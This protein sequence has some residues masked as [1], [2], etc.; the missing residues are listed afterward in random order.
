MPKVSPPKGPAKPEGRSRIGTGKELL[1]NVDHRSQTMRRYREVYGQ[2]VED[3]GGDPSEA[4]S[5][6]AKRATTLA[7]WCEQAEADMANG[8][9]IDIGEFTT[10]T[11]ALRRLLAD[12]GLQR[13]AKNVTPTI[14]QYLQARA[15]S[16]DEE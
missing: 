12:I 7:V 3:M 8:K 2:I 1:P 13:R 11:N 6:I 14:D 16:G 4:Q 15:K 10:A 5:I 9:P